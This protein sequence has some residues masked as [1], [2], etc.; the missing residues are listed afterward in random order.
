MWESSIKDNNFGTD[1]YTTLWHTIHTRIKH[2]QHYR[3]TDTDQHSKLAANTDRP[4]THGEMLLL[5]VN[6]YIDFITHITD[7][8]R[9]PLIPSLNKAGLQPNRWLAILAWPFNFDQPTLESLEHESKEIL[10][11]LYTAK[12][13]DIQKALEE[14]IEEDLTNGDSWLHRMSKGSRVSSGIE[15]VND[16]EGRPSTNPNDILARCTE[17]WAKQWHCNIHDEAKNTKESIIEAIN[18]A[19]TATNNATPITTQKVKTSHKAIQA[20]N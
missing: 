18:R 13:R 3:R 7:S 8:A 10:H 11:R 5:T 14:R 16:D 9:S 6:R 19:R 17:Q 20:N 15:A 1:L 4:F 2:I 12:R